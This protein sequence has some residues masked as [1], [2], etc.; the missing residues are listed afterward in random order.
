MIFSHGRDGP[1]I[2]VC[3]EYAGVSVGG[4]S[5]LRSTRG[6]YE[7]LLTLRVQPLVQ[8]VLPRRMASM[9]CPNYAVVLLTLSRRIPW[10]HVQ[11]QAYDLSAGQIEIS[12]V[13]MYSITHLEKC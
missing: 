3:Q 7:G 10:R 4:V 13:S 12:R 11:W 5:M 1:M 9:G 6:I 2:D 8:A